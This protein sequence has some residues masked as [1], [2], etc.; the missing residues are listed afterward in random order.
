M[1]MI[2]RSLSALDIA[3]TTLTT[4]DDGA[5]R[6]LNTALRPRG[7]NGV[8]RHYE[9]KWSE[10]YKFSP[11][12]LVWLL[13]HVKDFDV[14][15]IHALF[16]FSSVAAAFLARVWRVPYVVRPLGT[17]NEYGVKQ[18]RPRLKAASFKLIES[19]ILT[20]AAAI[21]FTSQ[22]E[23]DE[24]KALGVPLRGVVIP[25]GVDG[26]EVAEVVKPPF[27]VGAGSK[28]IL[29][30][31]RLD[32]KKNVEALLK[33]F[34]LVR[35]LH[36]HV[37]LVIAGDGPADYVRRL[38]LLAEVEGIA[39]ATIWTGHV[40][41]SQKRSIFTAA[42]V[43]VLPSLSENFGIA[44]VE[45]LIAGRPCVIGRG[46]A[47]AEVIAN[48]GAGLAT[49]P[50]PPSIAHALSRLLGD[51]TLCR[52]MSERGRELA[53]REYASAVMAKRLIELY[54]DIAI[55]SQSPQQGKP[56][57]EVIVASHKPLRSTEAVKDQ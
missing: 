54:S 25:L 10:F 31:S 8:T 48:A 16:S 17:L 29:F 13:L 20:H 53:Q 33:A 4:D 28:V 43:F 18:R 50:D 46:V 15:H 34:V 12:L 11:G 35:R 42:D 14:V 3:V 44:A 19:R 7:I 49:E 51:E 24:A 45:A 5:G 52:Q 30:L 38:K 56:S 2:E 37:S 55:P 23:W 9:R 41:G 1:A 6:R 57:S 32:P 36:P 22:N 27:E 26:D 40:D 21:H 39:E 47:I